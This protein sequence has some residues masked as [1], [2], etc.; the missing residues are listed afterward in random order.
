MG[1]IASGHRVVAVTS[2]E[3]F[4]AF[5]EGKIGN[6]R[7]SE[8]SVLQVRL[9]QSEGFIGDKKHQLPIPMIVRQQWSKREWTVD[10]CQTDGSLR[11]L[12]LSEVRSSRVLVYPSRQRYGR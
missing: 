5:Q 12:Y 2:Q 4:Y 6:Q 11:G 7:Q 10:E 3:V 1:V 9:P 8:S